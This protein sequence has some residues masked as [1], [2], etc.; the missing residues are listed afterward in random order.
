MKS[1]IYFVCMEYMKFSSIHLIKWHHEKQDSEMPK[2]H[3]KI[4]PHNTRQTETYLFTKFMSLNIF[5]AN[6]YKFVAVFNV[7]KQIFTRDM[8]SQWVTD[9]KQNGSHWKNVEKLMPQAGKTTQWNGLSNDWK[10]DQGLIAAIATL[11]H[12][13]VLLEKKQQV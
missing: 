5:L 13:T 6:W 3:F 4:I 10:E 11:Y 7:T 2:S 1:I 9:P 8:D 12:L